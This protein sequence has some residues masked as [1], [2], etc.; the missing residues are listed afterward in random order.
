[1]KRV[2]IGVELISNP[3]IL[4]LDEP[5]TG[6]DS[7]TAAQCISLLRRLT[8]SESNPPAIV[9]TIHQ[10]NYKIFNEFQKVYLLS[11]NGQNIY[12]GSPLTIVE[13]FAG[14]NLVCPGYCN[15]ADY[16]I[17]VAYGDYGQECFKKMEEH[18]RM[19]NF[20][21]KDYG[22]KFDLQ[23]VVN[24]IKS[25]KL[26]F[27]THTNLLLKRNWGNM[28]RDSNQFWFRNLQGIILAFMMSYL[29]IYP[30]GENDACWATFENPV[31]TSEL[32]DNLFKINITAAK[33]EYLTKISRIA[34]NAAFLFSAILYVMMTC[35]MTSVLS[36]PLETHIVVREIGNN[37]YKVFPYFLA[38]TLS[39]VPALVLSNLLLLSISYPMTGQIPE[40]WRF[41]VVYLVGNIVG[42]ICQTLGMLIGIVLANDVISAALVTMAM[43]LPQIMFAGFLVRLSGMPW[44]YRPLTYLSYLR[45][46]FESLMITIYGFGRCQVH[47]GPSFIDEFVNAQDPQRLAKNMIESFNITERDSERFGYLLGVDTM[48]ISDVLNKTKEYLGVGV[49]EDYDDNFNDTA[50]TGISNELFDTQNPSY[51]LSYYELNDYILYY[52]VVCLV[53]MLLIIKGMVLVALRVR[54]NVTQ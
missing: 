20:A 45:Y 24:K 49:Y 30:V 40:L 21:E 1:V 2:C 41:G 26:P 17:E 10:P 19:M 22:A 32:K 50:D 38:K 9:A 31:N 42:D 29:W 52:D 3:D 37:W 47:N 51:I 7:S 43:T 44:F 14:F 15:P 5:T 18:N 34:D 16:A 35:L 39:D 8:E 28:F 13:Y 54:T 12:F 25:K 46:A 23:K 33:D 11:R 48:C 6:L 53:I 27:W 4:V 36:F